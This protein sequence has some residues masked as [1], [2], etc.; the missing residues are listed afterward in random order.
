V[1]SYPYV[2]KF[3]TFL[4][5]IEHRSTI[6]ESETLANVDA[7]LLLPATC[8]LYQEHRGETIYLATAVGSTANRT[9]IFFSPGSSY[10]LIHAI[11]Q[12]DGTALPSLAQDLLTA[13]Q[14]GRKVSG[15]ALDYEDV[16]HI[17]GAVYGGT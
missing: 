7:I 4:S 12:A 10:V 16:K 17:C 6:H 15:E 8:C 13:V 11:L 9:T 2:R 5:A 3:F 14:E 1:T